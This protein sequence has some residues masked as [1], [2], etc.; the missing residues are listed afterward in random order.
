MAQDTKPA[1]FTAYAVGI[2]NASVC[3]SLSD[4]ATTALLNIEHPT[5]VGPWTIS[6]DS[7]FADG[8]HANPHPCENHPDT[9]R[10]VLF[11]C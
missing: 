10:H 7:H 11:H 6:G 1:E 4:E 9:H 8:E 3:T 2:C 5:G